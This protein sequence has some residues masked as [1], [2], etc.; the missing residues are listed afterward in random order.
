LLLD[1]GWVSPARPYLDV[2]PF[3]ETP[4]FRY[5]VIPDAIS[6]NTNLLQFEIVA[7]SD[8]LSVAMFPALDG[9]S[10]TSSLRLGDR[11]CPDWEDDWLTPTTKSIGDDS[12][13]IEL[14]GEFPRNCTATTQVNVLDRTVFADKLFRLLWRDIGGSFAGA[15]REAT[16]IGETRLLAEHRSRPLSEVLHDINKRSDNPVTRLTYLALSRNTAQG[17]ESALATTVTNGETTAAA[18]ERT[19]R[20]WLRENQ[21]DDSGLILENG[22][23]LSRIEK[24]QPLQLAGVLRLALRRPWSP[25][26]LASLPVAGLDGGLQRRLTQPALSGIA[27]LKTGTLRDVTALAGY[28]PDRE[29]RTVIVVAMV[30]H[31]MATSRVARPILDALIEAVADVDSGDARKPVKAGHR[32]AT[33][34]G[35]G[36]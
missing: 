6:L 20:A 33:G 5:N 13:Q 18:S 31:P 4:E 30:N 11:A 21:I 2:A 28:V 17:F 15:T 22:S 12:Y 1:R 10:V 27:R 35:V 9:I 23:G 29:G 16:N 25:E 34:D 24:I 32:R 7:N 14:R 3:D 8:T 26:F 19:V 36:P